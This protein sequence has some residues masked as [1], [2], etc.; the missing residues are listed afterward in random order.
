MIVDV[1]AHCGQPEHATA[2]AHSKMQRAGYA[3]PQPLTWEHFAEAMKGVDKALVFG[4]RGLATGST[5][6]NE[7]TAEWVKN[8][9]D[10]FIGFMA[11]DP[12]EDDHLEQ[13]DRCVSELG[14][15]G[16]KLHPILGRY[17]PADPTLF[18]MYDKAQRLRL[19]IVSHFGTHPD[20]RAPLKYSQPLL[21]DEI[22]QAFPDLK[23][24]MAHM[25]H[26]WQRDAAVVLRKH[27][28]V[29]AD[30]SGVWLRP[31]QGW[32]ALIGMIEWGVTDKLLFGS[33][34]PAFGTPA[35]C[36]EKTR[37]LN[38]Q[39]EGTRLPRIP[40]EVIE[41]IINRNALE[42]LGLE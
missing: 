34:F 24:V 40:E 28:N 39:L 36:M 35:E 7:F 25:A 16:I 37:R 41:G 38:D 4:V 19:P 12:T 9:P 22:A 14:L 6:P 21:V 33:D 20:A 5:S 17:N 18:P 30:I 29:Y 26:P 2:A 23:F 42:L 1:H 31:W 27:P 10:K 11:I 13:M 32:E 15:R 8:D 3:P